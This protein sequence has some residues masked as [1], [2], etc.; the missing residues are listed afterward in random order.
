VKVQE[1]ADW[2]VQPLHITEQL[3]LV[4]GQYLLHRLELQQEAILHQNVASQ[5]L[6]KDQPFLFNFHQALI[7]GL[8]LTQAQLAHQAPLVDAL[9]QARTF[10]PMNLDGCPY[11]GVA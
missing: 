9:Q 3:G 10:D 11:N 5:C 7:D 6:L 2:N 8:D 1:Q 4:N